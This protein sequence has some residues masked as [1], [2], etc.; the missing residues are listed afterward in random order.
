MYKSVKPSLKL[1]E[2]IYLVVERF[3]NGKK[4]D[5]KE[6]SKKKLDLTKY[7]QLVRNLR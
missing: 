5:A 2:V 1:I 3:I 4:A 6:V 7:L